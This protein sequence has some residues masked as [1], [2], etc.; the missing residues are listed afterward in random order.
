MIR[1]VE[2]S[3]NF[4]P[5]A[6]PPRPKRLS[7]AAG[8]RAADAAGVVGGDLHRGRHHEVG[9]LHLALADVGLAAQFAAF[10]QRALLLDVLHRHAA[11]DDV[12]A[13]GVLHHHA[14]QLRGRAELVGR[15]VA[16][17]AVG[18]GHGQHA[19]LV[20]ALLDVGRRRAA[21]VPAASSR[22]SA[23]AS[24]RRTT[25]AI[26]VM[27]R[28]LQWKRR[29]GMGA[30]WMPEIVPSGPSGGAPSGGGHTWGLTTPRTG[31]PSTARVLGIS[32]SRGPIRRP[33]RT[34]G[35]VIQYACRFASPP[36]RHCPTHAPRLLRS[37]P[38]RALGHRR[39]PGRARRGAAMVGA[40]VGGHQDPV[41]VLPAGDR[42][43]GRRARAARRASSSPPSAS[44][45]R[46]CGCCRRA[47]G[48]WSA[49]TDNLSLLI[50]AILG[51]LLA[52]LGAR[53][54]VTSARASAAEQR[55]VLA[56]EDTGIGIFDLD[57]ATR[58]VYLSPALALLCRVDARDGAVP[59]D[60]ADGA[61]CRPTPR[62]RRAGASRAS[63]ASAPP[64]TS[65]RC[66]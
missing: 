60:D 58:T 35:A 55:L 44:P 29:A 18:L 48:G 34:S 62:S 53:L 59:L 33:R 43:G 10:G 51:V 22:G 38:P 11:L 7:S 39:G 25:W 6:T 36:D 46:G 64:A 45:A 40:A 5:P 42:R 27:G 8:Q 1:L 32:R 19:Q 20:A 49:P 47:A 66:A 63:C 24:R 37:R 65:A 16:P 12:E 56:G 31:R 4:R 54:R 61:A 21:A 9:G 26:L 23:A 15:Q 30:K 57:L 13:A 52:A 3:L 14:D 2:A 41:P 50:Y 28:L 17:A